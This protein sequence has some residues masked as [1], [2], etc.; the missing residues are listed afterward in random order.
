MKVQQNSNTLEA[1]TGE[2][3]IEA[4]HRTQPLAHLLR[5]LRKRA[6]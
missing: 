4:L 1:L 5:L 2:D 6:V 3:V